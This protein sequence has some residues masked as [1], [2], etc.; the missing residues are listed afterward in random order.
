VEESGRG[1]VVNFAYGRR[2]GTLNTGTKTSTPVSYA[3][4]VEIYLKLV[5]SKIA[6]GYAVVS[7]SSGSA[8]SVGTVVAEAD[9]VDTGLRPQLLNPI[10]ETEAE[11]CLADP[12][13]CV[14]EKYDGRR[15]LVRRTA[16]GEIVAANRKG[17][18]IGLPRNV[19]EQLFT[20]L[21]AFVVDGELVGETYHVFDLLENAHGDW[22]EMPYAARLIALHRLVGGLGGYVLAAPTAMTENDKRAL[23]AHLKRAG[24]EGAV[25]KNLHAPWSEGRSANGGSQLK[26]K[27]W[28]SCSCV[29]TG[30]NARRSVE[31]SLEGRSVGNV[32][33][34][35]N[36]DLPAVGQ[37]VEI[38]YLYV[39]GEDGS[40]YQP[41]YLGARE[42]VDAS[43]CTFA[44]QR[45]KRKAAA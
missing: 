43:D 14:Q 39:A 44:S 32:T 29:V 17:Q 21:G 10:D 9:K 22:R 38:R 2:G 5:Q 16:E 18:R 7:E 33:I 41:V 19:E 30:V 13:W 40:L 4:A 34:P 42:D 26:C 8:G 36:H 12:R 35:P 45:L 27:F 25:F 15:T 20:L 1:H 6:K 31:V 28:A 37:V 24:R 11:A 23:F 3:E